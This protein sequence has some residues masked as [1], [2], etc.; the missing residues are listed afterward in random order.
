MTGGPRLSVE[1]EMT[2]T[3]E[4]ETIRVVGYGDLVVVDAPSFAAARALRRDAGRLRGLWAAL[5]DDVTV[6]LRIRGASV[7]RFG[8]GARPGPL[9]RAVGGAGDRSLGGLLLAALGAAARR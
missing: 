9:S 4:D 8:P 2:L 1:A 3:V 7:A 6:D 5:P